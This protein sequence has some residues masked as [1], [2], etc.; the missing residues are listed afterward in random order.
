MKT[1][2]KDKILAYIKEKK[3]VRAKEI[4]SFIG[5]S[6]QAAFRQLKKLQKDGK[7]YKVGKPPKVLYYAYVNTMINQSPLIIKA[8]N[9]AS[10][11]N[12]RFVTSDQLCQTRDVFQ[13]RSDR[14]I[15]TLKKSVINENLVYLLAAVVGEIGNNSFDHNIGQWQDI[16]GNLFVV[17][18]S[19]REIIIADRGQGVLS[20]LR[21]VRPNIKND[22]EALRVAFSELISGR[23]PEQRGNGLKFV[24]KVVEENNLHLVFYSGM[25]VAEISAGGMNIKESNI[26]IP[27]T[28][29]YLCY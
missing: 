18:E 22:I 24:K 26:N 5:I 13:A 16:P 25:S 28:L 1:D 3:E 12:M 23:A 20:S 27:G 6:P 11:G 19:A 10:S 15:T 9:W 17:D 8:T 29:S 2:T 4:V 14:L 7:I 21:R